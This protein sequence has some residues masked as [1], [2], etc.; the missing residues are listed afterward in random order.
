[1]DSMQISTGESKGRPSTD[2]GSEEQIF[3]CMCVGNCQSRCRLFV[4]VVDGKVVKT[5][6]APFPDPRYNRVCLRG[7]SHVQRIYDPA[8]IKYPMKRVGER[9]GGQWERITWEEAISEITSKFNKYQ[10]EFGKQSV[11]VSTVSGNMAFLNGAGSLY[12]F[13]NILGA[14]QTDY[15]LDMSDTWGLGRVIG[16]GNSFNQRND[17][18]DLAN[19]K[20]VIVWAANITDSHPHDWRFIVDAQEAGA[21]IVVIDP[22]FTTAAAKA[23]KWI[24]LRP[25]SDPALAMSMAQVIISEKLFDE[26]YLLDHTV[27]PFLVREDTGKFLRK[28]DL[29]GG[30][31]GD[32]KADAYVVW[33]ATTDSADH[34]DAVN[35]PAL[36]GAFTID[37]IQVKTAFTLLSDA[38]SAYEPE[39]VSEICEVDAEDIRTIARLYAENKPASIYTGFIQYDNGVQTGHAWGIL[40]SLTGNIAK[41]GASLGHT[42]L[43]G[44]NLNLLPYI[45][46]TGR[47][48]PIV[49]WV[50]LKEV[51]KS[52]QFRGKAH[53]VKALF[54]SGSNIVCNGSNQNEIINTILPAFELIVAVDMV[55]TDTTRYA[56]LVLP[57]S[58]WFER[59]ELAQGPDQ[60]N[61]TL[62]EKAIEPAFES[63][64]DIDIFRLI[65]NGM[66]LGEHYKHTDEEFVQMLI[67]TDFAR[68]S[69]LTW[70]RLKE[71]TV[72]QTLPS[73]WINWKGDRFPTPS[74]R[75]EF[76]L[77]NPKPRVNCGVMIDQSKEHLPAFTPPIE[78]W[79]DNPL[80]KRFPLV[81]HT[82][83]QRWRLH[84][85]W[86]GT[87]WLRELDPEPELKIH[88][89]DAKERSIATGDMVEVFNDRGRVLLRAVWSE[90]QRP[91]M[92]TAPKGWQRN[93]FKG[94]S[95][96]ELTS[97]H[98]N[99]TSYN[100]CF[101]DVL[102]EVRKT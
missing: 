22:R 38:M 26:A 43:S 41:A 34:L 84:S 58:H 68:K 15:S 64:S 7:L 55:E 76:Y 19:A 100:Q 17:P 97:D 3:S 57:A 2:S 88:P 74:G 27:A 18:A 40:A 13:A 48:A 29:A 94:G 47:N 36:E 25:G 72:I 12:R 30:K 75:L 4:H 71:E 44:Y 98:V 54:L 23:D 78:A 24:S 63:K 14:T 33:D 39:T 5:S 9:G 10:E 53:P 60:P 59:L 70:E 66:G 99:T 73:Q 56:D 80:K 65:T 79:P 83:R 89:S 20:T 45:F 42:G 90:G 67:D 101:Y 32:E 92:V 21:K 82:V 51:F 62:S 6:M 95:Y 37:G 102:C 96:Q 49:P 91:G 77:E 87:P 46:P 86:H 31:P 8:R 28:S 16:S 69:G 93:Q 11:V 81:Y 50:T 52:G 1:M 85:Q 61:T 35:K